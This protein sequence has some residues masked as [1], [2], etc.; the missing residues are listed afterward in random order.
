MTVI[1]GQDDEWLPK[2]PLY[3][4]DRSFVQNDHYFSFLNNGHFWHTKMT[5]N[6]KKLWANWP[7]FQT[8][9]T[10]IQI[11]IT[12]ICWTEIHGHF[13]RKTVQNNHYLYQND[14]DIYKRN[15]RSF[16]SYSDV[17]DIVMLVT[18]FGYFDETSLLATCE[19]VTNIICQN[20]V[21]TDL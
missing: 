7:L 13:G 5:I 16:W 3:Q 12:V 1:L 8:K 14:H 11:K 21:V 2:W 20:V 10:V 4:N 19:S 9:M 18:I 17:G 15:W 6:S